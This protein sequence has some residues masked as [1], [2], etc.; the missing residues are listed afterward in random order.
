MHKIGDIFIAISVMILSIVGYIFTFKFGQGHRGDFGPAGWPKIILFS[1]FTLAAILLISNL[2]KIIPMFKKGKNDYFNFKSFSF[3]SIIRNNTI[4]TIFATLMYFFFI[5]F[6]GH[7]IGSVLFLII[8][9]FY[10]SS[11]Q[12]N[13]KYC[14]FSI[15]FSALLVWIFTNIFSLHLPRGIAIFETISKILR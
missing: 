14:I 2:I 8:L 15:V 1:S 9:R 3:S 7:F 10:L 5:I 13:Y 11:Y 12:F 4:I 6:F